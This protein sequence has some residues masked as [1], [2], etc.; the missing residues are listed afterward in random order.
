[1]PTWVTLEV[2]EFTE[3]RLHHR[4]SRDRLQILG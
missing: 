1:M 2:I 3:V 4:R